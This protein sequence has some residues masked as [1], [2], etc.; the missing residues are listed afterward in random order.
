MPSVSGFCCCCAI[1]LLMLLL[2]V[3]I[4]VQ[5]KKGREIRKG[6]SGYIYSFTGP[7][8][9]FCFP[10]SNSRISDPNH[11]SYSF[12]SFLV[13]LSFSVDCPPPFHLRLFVWLLDTS[14]IKGH[15]HNNKRIFESMQHV[16]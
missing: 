2:L 6:C 11:T 15:A 10:K 7:L 5:K 1:V 12:L 8:V 9:I 14:V 3:S 4:L 16:E 13:F